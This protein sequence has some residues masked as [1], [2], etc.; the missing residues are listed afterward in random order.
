[1]S[2]HFRHDDPRHGDDDDDD[3]D[4]D[5]T[6][7]LGPIA[8]AV[9]ALIDDLAGHD[10]VR[11]IWSGDHTLWQDDPTE[12]ADRLGWLHVPAELAAAAPDLSAFAEAAR[13]DGLTHVV[14]MG[15][16]GSSLFPEVLARSFPTSADHLA[17]SVLDT[18][19]P[20][21]VRRIIETLPLDA[22]LFVASSKSGS[23]IET[24]SH[25]AAMSAV[26]ERPEQFVAITDPGSALAELGT[27][28]GFRAVF[29]NRPDIGGRYS[30]L[31][32]FGMVP[33]ALAGVDLAGMLR[34]AQV[35]AEGLAPGAVAGESDPHEHP[36]LRL[37][38]TLAA[39]VRA[40]RDKL[41]LIVD[42]EIAAFGLWL[43][44]LIAES[45]GKDGTGL[46]PIVDEPVG[47]P[48]VYGP[49][50]LFVAIGWHPS[51]D[52]LAAAGHPVVELPYEGPLGLG[53]H[54]LLWEFAT[55]ICGA[56]LGINPFDQP[57]VAEAKEATAAVLADGLPAIPLEPL[58]GLLAQ[59]RPGDYLAI[60][61]YV[62]PGD[63]VVERL[64]EVRAVLRDR[65]LVATALGLG[66]RYLHSTGQLHK[67]GPP[68]GVF[69]QVVGD[70]PVDVEIPGAE[71]GFSTLKQAQAAGD[72]LA[73]GSHDLRAGRVAIDDLLSVLP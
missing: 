24:R 12:V 45:T 9:E 27:E 10:A 37:G 18:T 57:N 43:E 50:R 34:S 67:G 32:H 7:R 3:D 58:G 20:A 40:G 55:A 16:G 28:R 47:P 15:M 11:R 49:D 46:V 21:A 70:D 44:Q 42:P 53:A 62:D 51:L 33:A 71:Y 39:A 4:Y 60:Q 68:S 65:H 52:S 23:T 64:R 72:L 22:T 17:L 66:P 1:M 36:G 31:S 5:D 30:A 48:E 26:V 2:G 35:M 54:V 63:E 41:T 61:A 14:V 19:D 73:L 25:L 29:E 13:A 69:V 38:A 8:G 56:A 59:L 6:E